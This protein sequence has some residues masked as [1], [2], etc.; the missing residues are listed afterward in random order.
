MH[1]KWKF[2]SFDCVYEDTISILYLS[3]V[4][5]FFI[6]IINCNLLRRAS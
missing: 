1:W 3:V 4:I 5:C 2:E 6:I